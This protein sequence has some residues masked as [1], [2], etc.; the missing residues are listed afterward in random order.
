MEYIYKVV[1]AAK[2]FRE[3]QLSTLKFPQG[4]FDHRH[5]SRPRDFNEV[6]SRVTYNTRHFS[7]NYL[8]VI[9]ILAIYALLT[10]T[11]LLIAFVFLAGGFIAINRFALG[12]LQIGN[13]AVTQ[14][15]L[16]TGLF[17]IGLLLLWFA[18]PVSTFFWLVSSSVILILGHAALMEP[19][20]ESEYVGIEQV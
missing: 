20:A 11:L 7:G 9:G 13:H 17:V 2:G 6:T 14:K 10:N 8:I 3:T 18:S 12:P 1:D 15:S 16:Y 4:F 19:E 5:L